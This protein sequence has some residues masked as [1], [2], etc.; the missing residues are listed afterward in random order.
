MKQP[1]ACMCA[2]LVL[3]TL[4]AIPGPA[5]AEILWRFEAEGRLIA[6][7]TVAR[8]AI[9]IAA[10]RTVHALDLE[11]EELW[12]RELAGEIAAAVTV[13][14]E[15]LYV[16]S[17]AGLHALDLTGEPQWTYESRDL[18]PI[19]DGRTWG[20]GD[21]ILADP[22]G[23]YRSAPLIVEDTVYFGSSGGVHAVSKAAGEALWQ[24][25]IGPVTADL[26]VFEDD[27][28]EDVI[29]VASWNDSV[30]GLD[31]ATGKPRWRFRARSNTTRGVDWM[32][33]F[34]FNLSPVLREG[35]VFLGSRGT[36]FYAIDASNGTEVWSS[37]VGSSWIGSPA[38]V[39]EDAVYYG[40]SDGMA[41][42]GYRRATGAQTLFFKTGSLVFAQPELHGEDLIVGTLSGHLFRIDPN[43]GQG[44]RFMN[45]GPEEVRYSEFFLPDAIP[46][47]LTRYQASEWSIDQM[48]SEANA[49]LNL[50]VVGDTAFVGTGTGVLYAVDLNER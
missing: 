23:W 1:V 28:D 15:L 2:T 7:P 24:V 35:V 47:G 49:I 31:V 10:G 43:T 39:T 5:S 27:A 50:A 34:G 41:V 17:S 21:E 3:L 8:D 30:Y 42:M 18:G 44:E 40:L 36:F 11:G 20:W 29:V 37:K 48:L 33:Y 32:G 6:K 16:H 45:L 9:Y 38:V 13:E 12:R 46:E 19:V 4:L 14:G 26:V 25:P 22:W